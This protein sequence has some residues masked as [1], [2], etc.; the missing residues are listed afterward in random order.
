MASS[1]GWKGKMPRSIQRREPRV[2]GPST[3]TAAMVNTAKPYST[4]C[5]R[6]K[7]S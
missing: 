7:R 6:R 2:T 1:D 3:N 5:Q 4:H